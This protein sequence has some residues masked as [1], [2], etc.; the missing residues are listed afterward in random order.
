MRSYEEIKT[1]QK[2][3]NVTN[4]WSLKMYY[5]FMAQILFVEVLY[6]VQNGRVLVLKFFNSCKLLSCL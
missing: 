4:F 3:L 5:Y 6:H 1:F 2:L